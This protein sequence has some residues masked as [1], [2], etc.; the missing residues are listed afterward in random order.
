MVKGNRTLDFTATIDEIDY[1]GAF[2][3]W[4]RFIRISRSAWNAVI[5]TLVGTIEFMLET[6]RNVVYT[7]NEVFVKGAER[8]IDL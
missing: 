8:F 4:A 6:Y 2:G 3:R 1:P 5:G 7:V